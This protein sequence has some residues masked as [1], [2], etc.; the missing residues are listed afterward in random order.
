MTDSG[1]P[2]PLTASTTLSLTINPP[3]SMPVAGNVTF[4][5]VCYGTTGPAVSISIN[6][7]PVQTTT[8]DTNGNF[9]FA[10][11]PE[12]NYTITPSLTGTNALFTPATQNVTV[13]TAAR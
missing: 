8:T 7:N 13:G 10:A 6:T 4:N 11:V 1:T 12:G 2:T 3:P 5:N 9:S